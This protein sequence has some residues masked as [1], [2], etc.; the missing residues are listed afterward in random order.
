MLSHHLVD[1]AIAE[2]MSQWVLWNARGTRPFALSQ[3]PGS[4]P[5]LEH[6]ATLA[7]SVRGITDLM[8]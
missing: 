4:L 5:M 3:A 8:K 1:E 2:S 7:C 6:D